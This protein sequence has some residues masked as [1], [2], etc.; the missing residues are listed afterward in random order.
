ML[1][2]VFKT[3]K[4]VPFFTKLPDEIILA[5]AQKAVP[6]E[7]SKQTTI[8]NEGDQTNSL[9]VILSGKVRIFSSYED[10]KEITLL[11]E[12]SGARLSK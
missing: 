1:E 7:F 11:I 2:I 8:I 10:S 12:E 9:Y 3:L 5:L 6:V 4:L